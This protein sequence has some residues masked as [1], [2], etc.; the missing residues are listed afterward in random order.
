[1]N[2]PH[3]TRQKG[4]T[5]IELMLAMTFVSILLLAIAMTVIQM[6]NTYNRGMA[7]KEVNQASRAISDDM[8]RA[9]SEA[10]AFEARADG[11]DTTD[12]VTVK[13]GSVVVGGRLCLGS[14]S[15]LWNLAKA[16]EGNNSW[17]AHLSTSSGAAGETIRF[18]KVPDPGR[19]YCAKNEGVLIRKN[20]LYADTS[21]VV[22]LLE[23]G[24]FTMGIQG[25]RLVTTSS[26]FD[27][28]TGQR[29][30]YLTYTLG[31]GPTSAMNATQ[32]ACLPPSDPNAN[33]SA[34][35]VQQFAI[36]L[37]AGNGVN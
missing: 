37:R 25:M 15:Y 35:N 24:D 1:M 32:T 26:A 22:D 16:V 17:L 6:G 11:A 14:Y 8:Q 33:L 29:L 2:Q 9:V 36:V 13:N 31:T 18:V 30:Y 34:C 5:L 28:S 7:L 23:T 20:I 10:V 19:Q 27:E 4:F 12:Y 21:A 3:N